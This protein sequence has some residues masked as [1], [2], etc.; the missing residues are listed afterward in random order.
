[1]EPVRILVA[2]DVVGKPGREAC[3]KII[4][5]LKRTERLDCVILNVENMAGGSGITHSTVEE[6]FNIG[7]DVMTPGDHIFRKKDAEQL[8]VEHP[9]ILR[10]ANYPKGAP[11][12]GSVVVETQRGLK[13]GVLNLIGRV[14]LKTVDCPFET[15]RREIEKLKRE[16]SIICVDLHA[17]A[18]SEKVAMGWFLDGKVSAVYGTHTHV[19]T[20]DETIL[21]GGTG[22]I[23]DVGMCGPYKSV[24]GREVDNVLKMFLTQMPVKLDVAREDTRLSGAIFEIDPQ[25][26]KALSVKRVHERL[27]HVNR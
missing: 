3:A 19:Q 25:S 20:A 4:P 23:T 6:I 22:Y 7:V 2:G 18:T 8:L 5:Q 26:G 1:M 9:H 13:V 24:I 11:G 10:P 12:S 17:E 21:P 16:T 14:F 15:A 27:N